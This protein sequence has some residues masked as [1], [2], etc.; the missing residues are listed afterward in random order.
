NASRAALAFAETNTFVYDAADRMLSMTDGEGNI[1]RHAY[2]AV[3][4]RVST[5]EAAN[6]APRTTQ[7][8]YDLANR[9]IETRTPEG[10]I[11]RNTYDHVGNKIAED[12]LQSGSAASG[13]WIHRT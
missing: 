12:Q 8:A 9:L 10:G 7:F 1:T 5:T 6:S 13:V 4:N 2:D 11:A 3:G